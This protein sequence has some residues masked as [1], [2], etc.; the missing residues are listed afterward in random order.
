MN[1]MTLTYNLPN[2]LPEP[3]RISFLA[4]PAVLKYFI[5]K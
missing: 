4:V 2:F 1:N 3:V 5:F